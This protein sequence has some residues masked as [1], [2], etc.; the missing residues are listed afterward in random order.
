MICKFTPVTF[1]LKIGGCYLQFKPLHIRVCDVVQHQMSEQQKTEQGMHL[2][3]QDKSQTR[4]STC[5]MVRWSRQ[6]TWTH[7]TMMCAIPQR[8]CTSYQEPSTTFSS[9]SSSLLTQTTL[10]S[11]TRTESTFTTPTKQ[12][13]SSLVAQSYDD[14]DTRKQTYGLSPSSKKPRTTL[15]TQS[16]VTN[17][18]QNSYL[19]DHRQAR[20]STMCTS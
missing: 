14:G 13:S 2:A 5:P 1:T 12:R 17:A 15:Q 16:S 7:S 8:T 18:P 10:R 19:T 20:P 4:H 9:A 11:L 6:A 3:Q